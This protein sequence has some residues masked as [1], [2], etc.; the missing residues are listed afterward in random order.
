MSHAHRGLE[1]RQGLGREAKSARPIHASETCVNYEGF[2]SFGLIAAERLAGGGS[3]TEL[4]AGQH[5][6][7]RDFIGENRRD[8][9]VPTR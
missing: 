6:I 9:D 1:F 4:R 7:C 8:P 3:T 5:R 2:L